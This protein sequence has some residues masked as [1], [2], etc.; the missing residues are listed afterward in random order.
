MKIK[1]QEVVE[2]FVP[3]PSTAVDISWESM[4]FC[5]EED[6][7]GSLG[8]QR[9]GA[10]AL[11]VDD[12]VGCAIGC[13][14]GVGPVHSFAPCATS[15]ASLQKL[16]I[17]CELGGGPAESLVP[18]ATGFRSLQKDG[19]AFGCVIECA[20]GLEPVRCVIPGATSTDDPHEHF[21][22]TKPSTGSKK[23]ARAAG[24]EPTVPIVSEDGCKLRIASK[25][26]LDFLLIVDLF[27]A[28]ACSLGHYYLLRSITGLLGSIHEDKFEEFEQE[29]FEV[30]MAWHETWQV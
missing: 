12:T 6:E 19:D 14:P 23:T 18:H 24:L 1:L 4:T 28:R 8:P 7:D 25:A 13:Q 30:A 27:P 5:L 16:V 9:S 10:E 17:A 29:A 15:S 3:L 22:W 11:Q 26:N 20:L 21:T 2:S